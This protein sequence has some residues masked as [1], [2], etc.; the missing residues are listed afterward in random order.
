MQHNLKDNRKLLN[1]SQILKNCTIKFKVINLG[2]RHHLR[3]KEKS[4]DNWDKR[5]RIK[6]IDCILEETH[7]T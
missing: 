7:E 4:W 6:T 1:N 3:N 2:Q 5:N